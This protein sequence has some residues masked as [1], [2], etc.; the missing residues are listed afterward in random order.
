MFGV[1]AFFL[2]DEARDTFPG[3]IARGEASMVSVD[4]L[5]GAISR[6]PNR[7]PRPPAPAPLLEET[8]GEVSRLA[9]AY[10]ELARSQIG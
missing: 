9:R 6:I 10:A 2:D 7:R 3:L 1:P 4:S 8:L 5:I